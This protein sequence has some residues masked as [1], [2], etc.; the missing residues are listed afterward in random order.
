[1]KS[2][3]INLISKTGWILPIAA[4]LTVGACKKNNYLGYTPGSGAPTITS[5]HTFGK[6]DTTV[7]Y[8]TVITYN[9]AGTPVPTL[10]QL[11]NQVNPFDSVTTAGNLGNYYVIYGT[12]LGS[13]TSVTFNDTAAFLNRAWNTDHSILVSIPG[14]TPTSGPGAKNTLVVTTT[15]GSV[16]YKF[17]VIPPPPTVSNWSDYNFWAGSQIT[18]T[19]VGFGSVTSVGLTG[20]TNAVTIVSQTDKQMVLQFG[21]TTVNRANL[22]FT[23]GVAGQQPNTLTSTQELVDLDNAYQLFAFGSFK[24]GFGDWSW[25]HP[26][27]GNPATGPTHSYGQTKSF[28]L[29]FPKGGWQ[30]EGFGSGSA[31]NQAIFSGYKYYTFWIYGGVQ[32]ETVTL[33]ANQLPYVWQQPTGAGIF[34]ITVPPGV[35]SY[36]KIPIGSSGGQ[37]P[38]LPAAAAQ[39]SMTTAGNNLVSWFIPGPNGADETFYVDEVAFV[40]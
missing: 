22:V 25:T 31:V 28:E 24:N 33:A 29:V 16:S 23:Y 9:S 13:A 14:N 10:K 26:S 38:F 36:F 15:H 7:R 6:T 37:V 30:M 40:K 5:V 27:S 11:P 39:T 20:A 17:T 2:R 1:M 32:S 21:S 34:T 12:N 8:D 35:W 3:I 18:L 19:G 4:I